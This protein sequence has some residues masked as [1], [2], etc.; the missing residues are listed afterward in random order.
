MKNTTDFANHLSHFFTDFLIGCRNLSKNTISS[1]SDTF[2]LLVIYFN[3]QQ[4]I[5]PE[6]LTLK[7]I[8]DK[9][10]CYYLDWLQKGKKMF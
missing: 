1:Y 3:D 2:R 9:S 10:V 7:N 4:S 5:P 6:K 8:N